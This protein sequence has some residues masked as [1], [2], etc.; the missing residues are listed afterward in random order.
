MSYRHPRGHHL[1]ALALALFIPLGGCAGTTMSSLAPQT[2]SN[3]AA[4]QRDAHAKRVLYVSNLLSNVTV[5]PASIH[6]GNP[7][8]LAT[9]TDGTT[10]PEGLWV[11][12][13]GTLYVVNGVG[14]KSVGV[15]EYKR[16]KT[17]PDRVIEGGLIAPIA[18]AVGSD[19]TVYVSDVQATKT[20]VV[21]A[22]GPGQSAPE[23]TITLPDPA[24]A[25][26]AGSIAFDARGDLLVA[27]L[28][29]ENNA[30]H[31]FSIARGSS[32]PVDLGIQ[33]AGGASIAIDGAGNLYTA[34][35]PNDDMVAIYA[36]GATTP[37]RTY[38]LGTQVNFITVAA[39]GTLYAG[40]LN[41]RTGVT[42]VAEI[43][44]GASTITNLIDKGQNAYGVALGSL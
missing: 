28:A 25:L 31:V 2:T 39:N 41:Q 7:P 9:I 40:V 22:Y 3:A 44:P 38:S 33:G 27:T 6:A 29:P 8:P 14:Q 36:P 43:A 34:G 24:Y 30:V 18:V 23:R 32:Q 13:K 1:G 4:V 19:G 12:G 42:G 10:R 11:D 15:A 20:G 37:S 17:S 26:Q 21:V 16:G 35:A 5:F